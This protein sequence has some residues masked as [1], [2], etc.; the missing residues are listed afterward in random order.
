MGFRHGHIY[1]MYDACKKS[2]KFQIVA[3]CEEDAATREQLAKN[4][5][6]DITHDN[7]LKMLDE[8]E[9]DAIA[10]GDYY[11]KRG[12]ILIEAL[13]RGK[14]VIADK[15]ICTRQSELDEIERLAKEN[16]LK[17][18]CMLDARCNGRLVKLRELIRAGTIG[19]IHAINVAGQH[20]LLYGSR[21]SWYFE[22]DKHGGTINDIA[23]HAVDFVPW[24]TGLELTETVAA[25]SWNA[26]LKE[27]PYFHDAGQF[28]V[29]LENGCGFMCDV[30][31]FM[32]D[33]FGYRLDLYWRMTFYGRDGILETS[34]VSPKV[35]LA[36]NGSKEEEWL[37]PAPNTDSDYLYAFYDDIKGADSSMTTEHVIKVS[38]KSLK[39]QEAAY[40]ASAFVKL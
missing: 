1:A 9:C 15:P 3:A 6:A 11:G 30:S 31:Y 13:K 5:I 7:Y 14:H 27:V 20:P 17:V 34:V 18:G 26:F 36:K 2:D 4:N 25:L 32:P 40:S 35:R 37:D 38:R 16:N 39:I 22:E 19:E 10:C 33:S 21:P 28:I 12:A 24:I 29:R 23:I 8:V